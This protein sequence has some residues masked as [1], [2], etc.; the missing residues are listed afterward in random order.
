MLRDYQL[1]FINDIK[2][3]LKKHR[4]IVC[5]GAT[6][7]GKTKTFIEIIRFANQKG[8]TVLVLTESANIFRQIAHE[9]PATLINSKVKFLYVQSGAVY[10]AMAQTLWRRK[11]I[12]E[13]FNILGNKLLII[14]DE[15]HVGTSS[16]V[17]LT[18]P[19]AY[20][21][22][23]TA[24]PDYRVAKHLPLIY[25]S[26]VLGPQPQE[27]VE[28]GYLA[29]Y[30]H[31]ERR[32]ADLTQLKKDSK[33]EYNEQSQFKVFN[34]ARVY[35]DII[36]D[37]N[38]FHYKKCLIFCS[39]IADADVTAQKLRE[40]GFK[41]A[42]VH[43]NNKQS[44]IELTQFIHFNTNICVSVGILTKGFDLPQI[45]L[46]ILKRATTSLALYLQ[47]VGRASRIATGKERFTVIDYGGNASRHGLWNFEH[48]WANMWK[49]KPKK[50]KEGFAALKECP[51]CFLLIHP[52]VMICPECG[53]ELKKT[54]EAI[55][56]ESKLIS[57]VEDYNLIRGKLISE[58]TPNEL[59]IYARTTGKKTFAARVARSNGLDYLQQ[60]AREMNY[61]NGWVT[62]QQKNTERTFY[63]IEIK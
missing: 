7:M 4:N 1:K 46:L 39:S 5:Y 60:Y 51:N 9:L 28:K 27:L 32:A 18:L 2:N 24:S 58:L 15:A 45:D 8:T 44:D 30:Y 43:S 36:K 63:N 52:K 16:N 54:K 61:H 62:M 26:I 59:A 12:L 19:N 17:L 40:N 49:N 34:S 3:E 22:G 33:G 57:V 14:C 53:H 55:S 13:Q 10:I 21:L 56:I 47:M 25:Q 37:I 11:P 35:D 31:Y 6:G 23:F 50:K 41:L 29:P 42:L 20:K 38:T 48:D